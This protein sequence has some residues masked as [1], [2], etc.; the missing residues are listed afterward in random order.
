M[1]SSLL[2]CYWKHI[3]S[4]PHAPSRMAFLMNSRPDEITPQLICSLQETSANS[5]VLGTDSEQSP[6]PAIL[7][8][9][10]LSH[11]LLTLLLPLLVSGHFWHTALSSL[12][13]FCSSLDPRWNANSLGSPEALYLPLPP[14]L[15]K[16]KTLSLRSCT[17]A[18][19]PLRPL[20]SP[21]PCCVH[22]LSAS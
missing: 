8:S 17:P 16:F 5:S 7:G 19:I 2:S 12:V 3:Q 22:L 1:P 14:T 15:S 9:C 18:S 10:H 13:R 21:R 11:T 6:L 4:I 20:L